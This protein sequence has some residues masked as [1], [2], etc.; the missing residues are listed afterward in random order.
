MNAV[1]SK[2]SA[3]DWVPS[4]FAQGP[5]SGLQGGAIAGLLTAEIEQIAESKKLGHIVGI[6]ISFYRPTP[7]GT[8]RTNQTIVHSG[9]RVSF[10]ENSLTRED[11]KLCATL[12]ASLIREQAVE[13]PPFVMNIP[14]I[15]PTA[16]QSPPPLN[17]SHGKPWFMDTMHAKVG[18]DG[19]L[20]FKVDVPIA[21]G[22][23]Y[24]ARAVGPA[25]WCH[26]IHRPFKVPLADPN[27]DLT[28][29]LVRAPVGDWIGVKAKTLWQNSGIGVGLGTLCDVYGD[30]GSVSM[31]VALVSMKA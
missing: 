4:A 17:A 28:V 27:Q 13:F 26:G 18:L 23:G 31:S 11:G 10:V 16:L 29:N 3:G 30:I 9:Q 15:D 22:A 25:D 5:F 12:R 8:V 7:L 24:F 21:A 1:F 14:K 20:W 6:S 2:N 19:T